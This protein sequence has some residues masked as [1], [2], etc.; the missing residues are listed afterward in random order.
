MPNLT[1]CP[2]KRLSG[3]AWLARATELLEE[4]PANTLDLHLLEKRTII[5]AL[6]RTN[7]NRNQA[8]RLL[9]ISKRGLFIKLNMYSLREL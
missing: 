9:C 2:V 3:E 8:A 5:R 4:I 1:D 6:I 7:G